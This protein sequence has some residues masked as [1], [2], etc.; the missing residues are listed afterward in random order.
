MNYSSGILTGVLKPKYRV[1]SGLLGEDFDA[2]DG[3]DVFIDLNSFIS[4][5]MSSKKFMQT[6]PFSEGI[7]TD[8]VT[9]ILMTLKHWRDYVRNKYEDCRIFMIY[10]DFKPD[11]MMCEHQQLKSYLIPYRN[12]INNPMYTQLKYYLEE[13]IKI[14]ETIMKYLPKSYIIKCD[15]FDCYVIP[16]VI[17]D[18]NK[19][20]RKR[21]IISSNPLYVNYNYKD[22]CKVIYSKYKHDGIHQ[23]TDSLMVVQSMTKVEDDIMSIF[24]KNRVFFNV[25]CAIIGDSTRGLIGL[26]QLAKHKFATTLLRAVEKGDIPNDPLN[27]NTVLPA[28]DECYHDYLKQVYPLIDVDIHSN[29]IPSSKIERVKLLMTDLYDI[30]GLRSISINGL[31]LLELM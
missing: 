29:M 11:V 19:N 25:I 9:S 16:N 15:E 27:I 2:P 21:I 28:I 8:L 1:I 31:N 24:V 26:T 6:L 5:L 4:N 22:D 18:Y 23:V 10:N 20:K 14:V 17:D 13:S 12:K 30:D 7:E 3:L